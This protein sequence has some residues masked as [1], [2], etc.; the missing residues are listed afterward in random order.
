MKSAPKNAPEI[1]ARPPIDD[2]DQE[3]D[4]QEDGEAVGRDELDRDRAERA[5]TP[6]YIA[7]TPKVE[8]LVHRAC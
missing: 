2:A 4:R 5:G 7:L 3:A 6:V 1:E 8:R